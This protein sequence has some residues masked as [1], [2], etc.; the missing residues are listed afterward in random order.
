MRAER[1]SMDR[2]GFIVRLPVLGV[3]ASALT[4]SACG[5]FRYVVPR[6]VDDRVI[7]QVADFGEGDYVLVET[8]RADRP[9]YVH[10]NA[11]GDFSAAVGEAVAAG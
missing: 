8:T 5:G 4:A 6:E 11:E 9:L 7:V 10:R 1:E 2:R 3:A